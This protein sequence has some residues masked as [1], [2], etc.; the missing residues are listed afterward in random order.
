MAGLYKP[1]QQN[2]AEQIS[3]VINAAEKFF[4]KIAFIYLVYVLMMSIIYPIYYR[5]SY[6]YGYT[7]ALVWILAVN[8]FTQYFFS[9]TFKLLIQ[10]DQKA[11]IVSIVQSIVV[12]LN[13]IATVIIAKYYQDILVIKLFGVLFYCLQPVVFSRYVKNHY[14]IDKSIEPDKSSISQRWDGFWQNIAYFIHSNTDVVV[15]TV[16]STLTN[17]SVYS[18]YLLVINALKNLIISISGAVIPTL[19]NTLAKKNSDEIKSGFD[20]Y[21]FTIFFVSTFLF[22]SGMSLI[23]PFVT[24]YTSGIT[25]ADY[26]QPVFAVLMILAEAVYCLRDPYVSISYAAGHFKQTRIYATLEAIINIGVSMVLVHNYGIVGV[27]V[28]TLSAMQF[29]AIMHILYL[30]KAILNRPTGKAFKMMFLSCFII[31]AVYCISNPILDL[32]ADTYFQWI[33]LAIEVSCIAAALLIVISIIAYRSQMIRLFSGVKSK[34][35]QK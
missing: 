31:V 17:V 7:F 1:L 18:I 24:V 21:E 6:S 33:V 20:L 28:G 34:L 8:L 9:L 27:A 13:I 10:A 15:L 12:I 23:V 3:G 14:K 25:D 11:Y 16:F 29:R 19:G 2:N 5:A 26:Y 35:V 22:A 30:K 4:R 32:Q